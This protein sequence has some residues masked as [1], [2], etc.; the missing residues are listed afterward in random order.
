VFGFVEG[1]LNLIPEL[2]SV[3]AAFE[4][5]DLIRFEAG[6]GGILRIPIESARPKLRMVCARL[7]VVSGDRA[8]KELDLYGDRVEFPHVLPDG[9]AI[10]FG[11]D[12]QNMP[13]SEGFLLE[14]MG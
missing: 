4:E 14:S 6:K 12:F 8:G 1:L 5:P 10:R 3:Q 7:G 9:G 11:L 13:G 2:H